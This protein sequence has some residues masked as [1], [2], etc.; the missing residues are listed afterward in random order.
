MAHL[1]R[2][3]P[4]RGQVHR[5]AR[6]CRFRLPRRGH[7]IE[8]YLRLDLSRT[9]CTPQLLLMIALYAVQKSRPTT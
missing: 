2:T 5:R 4:R 1:A 9:I 3:T 6:A 7:G 8:V